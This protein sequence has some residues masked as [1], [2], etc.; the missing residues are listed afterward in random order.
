MVARLVLAWQHRA[1]RS[2]LSAVPEMQTVGLSGRVRVIAR[3]RKD[4]EAA[5]LLAIWQ[6]VGRSPIPRSI[7]NRP[8]K[9]SPTPASRSRSQVPAEEYRTH[10]HRDD[11]ATAANRDASLASNS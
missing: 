9:C 11:K 6:E 5:R 3:H 4:T 1:M 10:N 7:Q 2:C 8:V